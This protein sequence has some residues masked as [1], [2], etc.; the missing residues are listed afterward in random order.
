MAKAEK[1][2][3]HCSRITFKRRR[4]GGP[5]LAK[6]N[7]TTV[8]RCD[9]RKLRAHNKRQCRNRKGAFVVCR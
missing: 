6:S 2:S 4:K 9:N 7:W 8:L 5:V 1:T 3:A